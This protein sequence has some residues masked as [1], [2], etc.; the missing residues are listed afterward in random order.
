MR[1]LVILCLL[2]GP[3]HAG[4]LNDRLV[5]WYGQKRHYKAVRREVLDWHKTTKNACVAFVS[6]ALRDL[7]VDVPLDAEVDGESVSRLTRPL[8]RWLED[9]LGWTRVTDVDDLR[10]GDVVFTEAAEYPWHVYVF[11][12]WSDREAHLARVLD[13]QGFLNE[14]DVLGTGPGNFTPFAYALRSP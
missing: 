10:P 14:R 6:T 8:S 9:H 7:D 5:S 12:S 1:W 13:N 4:D 11:Y 2:A 3:A